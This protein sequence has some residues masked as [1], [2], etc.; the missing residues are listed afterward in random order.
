[1]SI[2]RRRISRSTSIRR[3]YKPWLR[4]IDDACLSVRMFDHF[5]FLGMD[6]TWRPNS[7]GHHDRSFVSRRDEWPFMDLALGMAAYTG[8]VTDRSLFMHVQKDMSYSQPHGDD[9]DRGSLLRLAG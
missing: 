7:V 2:T 8:V 5:L 4:R 3:I 9:L 1:M 6:L